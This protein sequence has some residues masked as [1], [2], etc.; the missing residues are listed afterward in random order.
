MAFLPLR[1]VWVLTTMMMTM[2][3]VVTLRMEQGQE[4]SCL[5]INIE[6]PSGAARS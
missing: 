1:S 4:V 3:V 5:E 6:L 2:G